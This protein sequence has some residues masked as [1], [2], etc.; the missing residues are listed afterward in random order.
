MPEHVAFLTQKHADWLAQDSTMILKEFRLIRR[1]H[2]TD[3]AK[4][5]SLL[6]SL[7]FLALYSLPDGIQTNRMRII[8]RLR[9][10]RGRGVENWRNQEDHV[11]TVFQVV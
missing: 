5:K 9:K 10:L 4:L 8:E 11:L 1:N 2:M 6:R 7:I 3:S